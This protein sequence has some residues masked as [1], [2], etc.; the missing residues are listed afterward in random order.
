MV[1]D[2]GIRMPSVPAV[3]SEPMRDLLAVAAALD[4]FGQGHLG[5]GR[6]GGGRRARHRA[7]DA[8]AEDGGVHQAAGHAVQ[9]RPQAFEHLFAQLGAKEDLAHPDEQGQGGQFP[10]RVASQKAENRL[11]PGEVVVK[12]AW[13]T[14]PQ[15][16]RV[17]AIQTPPDSSTIMTSSSRRRQQAVHGCLCWREDAAR[18]DVRGEVALAAWRSSTATT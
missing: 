14:Q 11:L 2:G 9:P 15:M 7:E 17:M 1:I 5:D 8:A 10:A 13:P 4:Q 16:A 12:K 6:A 3:A 18:S